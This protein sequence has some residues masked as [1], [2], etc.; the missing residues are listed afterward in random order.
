MSR[1]THSATGRVRRSPGVSGFLADDD[2]GVFEEDDT[3]REHFA[4]GVADHRRAA[5]RV[6]PGHGRIRRAQVD[7]NGQKLGHRAFRVS[8]WL[9]G[10]DRPRRRV[11]MIL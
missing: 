10:A 3:G 5:G 4:V 7:S 1:L 6:D 2:L 8:I 11:S 9:A